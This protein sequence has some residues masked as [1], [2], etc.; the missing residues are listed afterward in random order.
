MLG[1]ASDGVG[2]GP[3]TFALLALS[4]IYGNPNA[5][6]FAGELG[7]GVVGNFRL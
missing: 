2:V 6:G 4:A 1:A 5:R 7:L 3:A